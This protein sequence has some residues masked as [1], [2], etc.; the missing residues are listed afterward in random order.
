MD[1]FFPDVVHK[2]WSYWLAVGG[3]VNG[4]GAQQVEAAR[5]VEDAAALTAVTQPI[6]SVF[7]KGLTWSQQ[8]TVTKH[9]HS[10]SH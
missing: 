3:A 8:S 2:C 7:H 4:G 6:V 9:T 1:M 10:L 5:W